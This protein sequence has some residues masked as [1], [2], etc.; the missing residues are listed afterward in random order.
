MD[1]ELAVDAC[2]VELDRLRAEEERRGNVAVR[3]SL[4][5]L[6]RDLKLLRGQLLGRRGIASGDRLAARSQ[7]AAC[8]LRPG[9]RA[10][11]VEE[12]NRAAQM[13]TR[14]DAA[15]RASEPLAVEELRPRALEGGARSLLVQLERG[16]EVLVQVVVSPEEAVQAGDGGECPASIEGAGELGELRQFPRRGLRARRLARRPR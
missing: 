15:L 10:E 12:L 7:L 4:G 8:L 11:P 13:L 16:A 6:K 1:V 3:P 14:L 9:G 2:Q 5:D